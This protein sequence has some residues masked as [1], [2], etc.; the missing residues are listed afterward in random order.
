MFYDNKRKGKMNSIHVT[1]LVLTFWIL[2]GYTTINLI[3]RLTGR[4]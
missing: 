1:V 3:K 2:Y 4:G